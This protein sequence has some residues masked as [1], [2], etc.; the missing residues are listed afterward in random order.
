[1]QKFENITMFRTDLIFGFDDPIF[2]F[3]GFRF[4]VSDPVSR[5]SSYDVKRQRTGALH[6]LA[7]LSTARAPALASWSAPVI[8][9]FVSLRAATTINS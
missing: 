2:G 5:T 8:W 7:E 9:R 1:M 4:S 6:D 3:D